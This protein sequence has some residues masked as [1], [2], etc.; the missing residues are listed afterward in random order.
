V[1]LI[2]PKRRLIT[3]RQFFLNAAAAAAGLSLTRVLLP[4]EADAALPQ[5]LYK[6]YGASVAIFANTELASM[7]SGQYAFGNG[8]GLTSN[9]WDN[10]T[11]L[12]PEADFIVSLGSLTPTAGAYV[13]LAPLWAP[14]GSTYDDPQ[15]ASGQATT[16]AP[17]P[18]TPTGNHA[19]STTTSAKIAVIEAVP[20]RPG[21]AHFTFGNVSGVNL[22]ATANTIV[23]Y[24]Y[25]YTIG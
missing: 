21:K 9:V 15:Y 6:A 20:L 16:N 17:I 8:A 4:S 18:G 24:P 5:V 19:L 10:T 23:L 13:V 22:A 7:P 1:S 2:L 12:W 25:T 14:D 11:L 3:R